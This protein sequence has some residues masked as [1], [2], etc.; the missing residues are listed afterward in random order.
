MMTNISPIA[1]ASLGRI[2]VV[3]ATEAGAQ[4]AAE[5]PRRRGSDRV[6]VSQM[7]KFLSKLNTMPDVRSNLVERVRDEISRDGYMTDEKVELALDAMLD[8]LDVI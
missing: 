1:S 8:E 4:S 3:A 7:A 6:E 5:A 2:E